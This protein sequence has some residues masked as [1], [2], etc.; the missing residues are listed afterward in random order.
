MPAAPDTAAIADA[1]RRLRAAVGVDATFTIAGEPT[2]PPDTPLDPETG[3]PYDPFLEPET[4]GDETAVTI[5]CSFVHRPLRSIDPE[6][7]PIG[8]GDL[9]SA[10]LI[11]DVDDYPAV[12]GAQRVWVGADAWKVREWRYDIALGVERWLAYMERA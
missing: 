8:P 4:P 5:R 11:V 7:T 2:W 12:K 9:G 1:Q 6:A 10:E 3:R